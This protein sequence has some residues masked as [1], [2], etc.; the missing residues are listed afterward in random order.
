MSFSRS[1]LLWMSENKRMR[2]S[3][4]Y[5]KFVK[6]AV[7]KFMPGENPE[8]ALKAASRFDLLGIPT[9]FTHLGENI[10]NLDEGCEVC[11]KYLKLIDNI[12]EKKLNIEIS[13]KL[14]Q[15]GF[16]LS[17]EETFQPL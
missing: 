4:P 14:T 2:K 9:V 6:K 13:L 3:V 11:E 12:A 17:E 8:D 1:I 7:K 16:V 5:W 10:T 15:L